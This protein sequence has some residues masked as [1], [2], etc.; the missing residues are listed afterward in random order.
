M[1]DQVTSSIMIEDNEH[2]HGILFDIDPFAFNRFSN[3]VLLKLLTFWKG[4]KAGACVI[5]TGTAHAKFKRN[6]LKNGM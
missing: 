6:Y 2:E 1:Q 4:E 5:L 3:L